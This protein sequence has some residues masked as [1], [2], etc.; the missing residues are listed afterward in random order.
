MAGGRGGH[1]NDVPNSNCRPDLLAAA[2]GQLAHG[3]TTPM[4][5]VYTENDS[6]FAPAIASALYG[7]Y[8]QNGGRAQFE[9]SGP[10]GNDGHRLF[11]G[12]G[13]SQ[14]WGPLVARYLANRPVQ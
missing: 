10:F 7:A 4:L 5:W 14:I 9:H 11:F 12:P 2:A 8:S 1:Q 3:A 6:F 13:G